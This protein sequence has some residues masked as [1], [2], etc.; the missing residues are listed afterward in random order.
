MSWRISGANGIRGVAGSEPGQ[1]NKHVTFLGRHDSAEACFAACN[2]THVCKQWTWHSRD[3]AAKW[4]RTCFLVRRWP[5]V[6]TP[7]DAVTTGVLQPAPVWQQSGFGWHTAWY[8][9]VLGVKHRASRIE[10]R[11]EDRRRRT[12]APRLDARG[13]VLDSEHV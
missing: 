2:A 11:H 7:D 9:H 1:T 6:L 5:P 12:R 4:A 10:A 3:F 13:P 8:S